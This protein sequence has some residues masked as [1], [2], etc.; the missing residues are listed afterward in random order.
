MIA[1]ALDVMIEMAESCMTMIVITHE[2]GLARRVADRVV[3]VDNREVI[4]R[5]RRTSSSPTRDTNGQGN[6]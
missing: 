3:F 2:M 5:R 1:E 4:D 6:F